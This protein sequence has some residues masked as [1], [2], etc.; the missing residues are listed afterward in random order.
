MTGNFLLNNLVTYRDLQ[1]KGWRL[2][3][4]VLTFYLAC[5]VGFF[6]NLS[7]SETLVEKGLPWVWAGRRGA[8]YGQPARRTPEKCFTN[9]RSAKQFEP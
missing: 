6:T 9:R 4:G 2:L 7:V 3:P 1:L 5:S 8:R